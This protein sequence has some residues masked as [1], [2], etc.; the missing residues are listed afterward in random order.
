MQE[1]SIPQL[2]GLEA[3]LQQQGHGP[4]EAADEESS[5]NGSAL[6]GSR[7]SDMSWLFE[8]TDE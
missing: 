8:S 2:T 1:M 7:K 4:K 5:Q 3:L 6:G